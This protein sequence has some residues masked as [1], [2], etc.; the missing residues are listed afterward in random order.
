MSGATA[1]FKRGG[2]HPYEGKSLSESAELV[3]VDVPKR[4]Q[5]PV[6]QHL[7]KPSK[8]VVAKGDNVVV[9]QLLAE[10]DGPISAPVH[11]PVSGKVLKVDD[12]EIVGAYRAPII[13][14]MNDG[15]FEGEEAF[16]QTPVVDWGVKGEFLDRIRAAGVVGLGG[17]AFPTA[18]KLAP[19]RNVT[20][21]HL[22][23]NGCE[24]E[25]YLT[26]DDILMREQAADVVA[27]CAIMAGILGIDRIR[28]GVE[29]NKPRAIAALNEAISTK[30]Y[31]ATYQGTVPAFDVAVVPL[32]TRYPQGA[33]K[34][35]IDAVTG[36]QV[37]SGQLP[38]SVGCVVQ[39]VG[40]ALAVY[41]AVAT[42]KPLIERVITLTGGAIAN[43][44]NYLARIGTPVSA[45]VEAAGG[46]SESLAAMI[47]G[48]PMMGKSLRNLDVPVVK[49]MSGLLFLT[50][51]EAAALEETDCIRCGRCV[52][53]CPM[54]LAPCNI[55]AQAE[56]SK[57]EDA[58]GLGALDCV[59]CGSCQYAC[60]ARR[61]L[62]ARIRLTKY[63]WRRLQK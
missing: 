34:Q 39:N 43:P 4:V 58:V 25:P 59:E 17:A 5:V 11:S 46:T 48:G 12:G 31:L 14:I 51:A 55:T 44:G 26:A 45:L 42:G 56:H 61:Y 20:V 24:C 6:T 47:A 15:K 21:D 36:R 40:T 23:I 29:V 63:Y 50:A 32:K 13:D 3:R 57:W 52:D 38:F 62:V 60:P 30:S 10:A 9:G 49:G 53:A 18:V 16:G 19:P 7:G 54:G 1:G 35:L 41:D 8:A 22:L 27:G 37:P 2:V 28:I 33:E